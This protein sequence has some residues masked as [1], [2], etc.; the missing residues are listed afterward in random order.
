MT[1]PGEERVEEIAAELHEQY[2]A[3]ARRL[4]WPTKSSVNVPYEDLSDD[5][6]ELDRVFARWHLA[7][8]RAV[9][10][11]R[12]RAHAAMNTYRTEMMKH[13]QSRAQAEQRVAALEAESKARDRAVAA[14]I[15]ESVIGLINAGTPTDGLRFLARSNIVALTSPAEP[16]A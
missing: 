10:E 5:A 8:L 9:E 7:R 13:G 11:E 3:T 14:S 1:T 12:D 6:Q 16:S 15:W 4:G 2:L